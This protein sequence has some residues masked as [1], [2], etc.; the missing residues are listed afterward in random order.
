MNIRIRD[1]RIG[2]LVGLAHVAK[3]SYEDA[4]GQYFSD[5]ESLEIET[6][7]R[8]SK[9]YFESV[10]GKDHILVAEIDGKIVGYLQ[11]GEPSSD[12]EQV[13]FEDMQFRRLYILTTFHNRGIGSKLIVGHDDVMVKKLN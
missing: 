1:A 7:E 9:R 6:R 3:T 2:D 13:S 12:I 5:K 10:L 4:F 8:R 11:F